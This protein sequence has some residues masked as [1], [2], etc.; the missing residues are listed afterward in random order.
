MYIR[1]G[2]SNQQAQQLSGSE[3]DY[4]ENIDDQGQEE[5]GYGSHE[6]QEM[7]NQ[8][9]IMFWEHKFFTIYER[10]QIIHDKVDWLRT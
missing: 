3:Q 1:E 6:E 7:H 9:V 10:F 8:Q 2:P 4:Q 5:E